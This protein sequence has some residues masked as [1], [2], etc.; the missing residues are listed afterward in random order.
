[1]L[2]LCGQSK[3]GPMFE[4][5]RW[6]T[7][8]GHYRWLYADVNAGEYSAVVIF[9]G[10]ALFSPRYAAAA[11]AGASPLDHSAVNFV[12]YHRGRT[13]AWA[14]SEYSARAVH[15]NGGVLQIGDSR[16]SYEDG[17]IVI[18]VNERS[19]PFG[20]AVTGRIVLTPQGAVGPEIPLRRDLPHYWQPLAPRCS[21]SLTVGGKTHEGFG[22][23]DMNHGEELLGERLAGWR[24]A[25]VHDAERTTISYSL[26]DTICVVAEQGSVSVQ[27]HARVACDDTRTRWLL[28]VPKSI[29]TRAS[30]LSVKHTLESSPFYARL[31]GSNGEQH[32]IVE[33]ADFRRFLRPTLRWMAHVRMRRVA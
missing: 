21:A 4:M 33:I 1:M 24:W 5:P 7:Q 23:H 6:P 18:D 19:A 20:G 22:Y 25:R 29:V 27:R 26:D 13:V 28:A 14:F 9:M 15:Q 12:L 8:P 17:R 3:G 2:V 16:F 30:S 10:G 31:E 32:G 11:R